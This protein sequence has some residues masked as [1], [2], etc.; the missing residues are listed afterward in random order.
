MPATDQSPA[1]EELAAV[2]RDDW[3][4]LISLLVAG[5]RRLDLAEDALGDA[6]AAAAAHWPADGVPANPAGWLLT[7]ARRRALDRVRSEMVAARVQPLLITEARTAA[8]G[9][10]IRADPGD[11]LTDER[12][13]LVFCCAHPALDR[14]AASALT[15]RL[16]MGVPTSDIARLFLVGESTMAARLTRAKKKIV[17]AGVPF[18]L[19][20][21]DRI[22]ERVDGI[23]E[24]AYLAFT[25]GYAPGSGP[26][27]VRV[28]IAAEAIRLVRVLIQLLPSS[29]VL[30]A[31]LALLLLQHSRRDART[32]AAGSAVLLPEQDRRRWHHDEIAEAVNI[33]T[34]LLNDDVPGVG[35]EQVGRYREYLLQALIA[36]EHAVA[37]TA[38]DTDWSRIARRYGEL[39]AVTGSP[40]VR[41]NRAVAVAEA[42]GPVAGLALLDGLDQ[43]LP[44][45]HRLPAVRAELLLRAD[46]P[47][48]AAAQ[49]DL[50]IERCG[51]DI[52]RAHL[53]QRRAALR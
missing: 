45:S 44:G 42:D 22:G 4:R 48:G 23:A 11:E 50:A 38:A 16:V 36:A 5:F 18:V 19:P 9:Q 25:A 21:P 7:A 29:Q 15:L 8:A 53:H 3:G 24:I 13:R 10:Q 51:N 28:E 1:A 27:L 34:V 37:P 12:L 46:D 14:A 26:D 31:L 41:L 49:F 32:D 33:L 40:V 6:V 47:A 20:P 2:V 43:E 35:V 52:E 17:T 39:E 30:R